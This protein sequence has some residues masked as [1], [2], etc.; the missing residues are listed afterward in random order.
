MEKACST[1]VEKRKAYTSVFLVG[2][3]GGKSL[4]GRLRRKWVNNIKM[5]LGGM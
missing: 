1:N 4:L 2:K 5:D 3:P